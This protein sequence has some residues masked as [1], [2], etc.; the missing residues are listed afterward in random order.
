MSSISRTL[1]GWISWKQNY[2]EHLIVPAS[3]VSNI[4]IIFDH[5]RIFTPKHFDEAVRLIQ[6]LHTAI[7]ATHL[8]ISRFC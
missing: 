8:V 3:K 5:L 7:L 6:R 4:N 1:L 2:I